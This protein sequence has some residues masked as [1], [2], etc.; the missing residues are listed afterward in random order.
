MKSLYQQI[1]QVIDYLLYY[2]KDMFG[3]NMQKVK[4]KYEQKNMG[5]CG[6]TYFTVTVPKTNISCT[7]TVQEM[8][9]IMQEYMEICILPASQIPPYSVGEEL[10]ESLYIDSIREK[11]KKYILEIVYI[12]DVTAFRFVKNSKR[13]ERSERS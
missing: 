4:I 6:I 7:Y 11:G 1:K 10:L 2:Y 3:F 12:D 9:Q 5:K 13:S 8:K